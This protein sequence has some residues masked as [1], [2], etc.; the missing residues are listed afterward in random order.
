MTPLQGSAFVGA[1]PPCTCI[2]IVECRL[3]RS[4]YQWAA[5]LTGEFI[6]T[7]GIF[8]QPYDTTNLMSAR[9]RL[10]E[11]G[12]LK[13]PKTFI[14]T[15]LWDIEIERASGQH[16]FCV[17]HLFWQYDWAHCEECDKKHGEKITDDQMAFFT[18]VA[19]VWQVNPQVEFKIHEYVS[20]TGRKA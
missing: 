13:F 5:K 16:T 17:T 14:G 4:K 7:A 19:P 12:R 1:P 15:Y 2:T 20:V 8:K 10:E 18:P 11:Y 9:G 3:T 6:A